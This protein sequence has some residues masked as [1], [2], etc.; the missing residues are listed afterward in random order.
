MKTTRKFTLIE[1]LVVIAIIAIIASLLLP[2][3]NAARDK[4]KSIKCTNNLKQFF[5]AFNLY[6]NDYDGFWPAPKSSDGTWIWKTNIAYY[7]NAQGKEDVANSN[8]VF[9]CPAADSNQKRT[10]GMNYYL[11]YGTTGYEYNPVKIERYKNLEARII[12]ADAD[13][14]FTDVSSFGTDNCKVNAAWR[15]QAKSNF[16][17]ADGSVIPLKFTERPRYGIIHSWTFYY[18]GRKN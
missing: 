6:S 10:Y 11:N 13:N 18:V 8:T 5:L 17:F 4:A 2:A 1:L 15:H 14:L 9:A 16:L 7:I 12:I 3:L